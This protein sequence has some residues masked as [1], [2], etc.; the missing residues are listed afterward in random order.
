[1]TLTKV[2]TDLIEGDLG[3]GASEELQVDTFTGD[4]TTVTFGLTRL[5]DHGNNTQVYISGVYQEKST[6]VV[7]G[8]DLTFS[9]APAAG[10]SIEA[11][12]AYVNPMYSGDHVKKVDTYNHNILINPSFTVSQRG[13]VIDHSGISYGPDRWKFRGVTDVGGTM[14]QSTTD[15]SSGINKLVVKHLNATGFSYTFQRVEAV[16]LLGLYGKEMTFSFSY[17]DQGGSGIPSIQISSFDSSDAVKVLFEGVPT[18]LGNNRWTCTVTLS[19]N[20]G[21]IPNSSERGLALV[22]YP[23]EKNTAP[24]EWSVWETKLEAGSVAT[25]FIARS[26]GEELAL[27]QRYYQFRSSAGANGAYFRYATGQYGSEDVAEA[28][29][30]LPVVMRAIPTFTA[31]GGSVAT[32]GAGKFKVGS[33]LELSTDGCS[34][35]SVL[36]ILPGMSGARAGDACTIMSYNNKTSYITFDAEL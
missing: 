25:P 20:D 2:H 3:G 16:N 19:T 26:Y 13:A 21:T 7:S 35:A 24:D 23:N 27:C 14:S 11:V 28:V 17:S 36:I 29:I 9:E 5:P 22:I 15:S 31:A 33:V 30:H 34:E 32:Y 6:Y 10:E 18:S 4:G 12:V 1:M 8:L